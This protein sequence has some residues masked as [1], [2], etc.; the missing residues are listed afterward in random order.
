MK[1]TAVEDQDE[2]QDDAISQQN[3]ETKNDTVEACINHI[4]LKS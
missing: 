1:N 3:N 2:D 4:S